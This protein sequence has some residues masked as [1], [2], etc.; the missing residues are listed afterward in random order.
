MV[1]IYFCTQ[2]LYIHTH[3]YH[4][5]LHF[6]QHLLLSFHP[7]LSIYF[8]TSFPLPS[9]VYFLCGTSCWLFWL[10]R[11]AS[12]QTF[13]TDKK[14][15]NKKTTSESTKNKYL[16]ITA[17]CCKCII[18]SAFLPL[19]VCVCVC[20]VQSARSVNNEL[21]S[22]SLVNGGWSFSAWLPT[23]QWVNSIALTKLNLL[24]RMEGW[25]MDGQ[26]NKLIQTDYNIVEMSIVEM[27]LFFIIVSTEKSHQ[28]S[29]S[30]FPMKSFTWA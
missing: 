4:S 5:S 17:N 7:F 16:T 23:A 12:F 30:C 6:R 1:F 9:K 29:H 8:S 24:F 18:N 10:C 21:Y 15:T 27:K 2:A 25:R 20:P 22:F 28:S 26:T 3:T 14:Q 11:H 19:V 13:V